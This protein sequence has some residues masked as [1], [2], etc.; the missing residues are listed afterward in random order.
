MERLICDA[1]GTPRL[2]IA[3]ST[4]EVREYCLRAAPLG[5]AL[6]AFWIERL[7]TGSVYRIAQTWPQWWECGCPA[8]KYRKDRNKGCKHCK[9]MAGL[10]STHLELLE[11]LFAQE[12]ST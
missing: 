9:K 12:I 5:L 3:D 11:L 1:D 6:R 7:D 4:G 10:T 8:F 2:D